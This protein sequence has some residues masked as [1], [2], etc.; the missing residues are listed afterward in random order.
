[1]VRSASPSHGRA[2]PGTHVFLRLASNAWVPARGRG[3][4]QEGAWRVPP[5]GVRPGRPGHPRLAAAGRCCATDPKGRQSPKARQGI[6]RMPTKRAQPCCSRREALHRHAAAGAGL[7][8]GIASFRSAKAQ[9][10]GR[11]IVDA[12]VT[13]ARG[14]A[15]AS[16][17]RR[18]IGQAHIAAFSYYRALA[19]MDEAG[20]DRVVIVPPSWEAIATNTRWRGEEMAA[21][22]C[23]DG[24][25]AARR[26]EIEGSARHWK[27]QPGMLGVRHTFNRLQAGWLTDGTP[28]GSGRPPPR[29]AFR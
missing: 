16:L 2:C 25:P 27:D 23:G 13:L 12:Q 9:P 15:R 29:P 4:T 6:A 17:A 5:L 22:F 28:I 20:V 21:S 18:R 7:A 26:S 1:M 24:P 8:I 11:I 14:Y 10:C 19:R 3:M